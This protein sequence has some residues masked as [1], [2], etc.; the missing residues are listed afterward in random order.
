MTEVMHI[1]SLTGKRNDLAFYTEPHLNCA[2]FACGTNMNV[3]RKS[4]INALEKGYRIE[5]PE[6][7]HN[8]W[9]PPHKD[10]Q[11][12]INALRVTSR[13]NEKIHF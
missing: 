3:V 13:Q 6:G 4:A 7:D 2:G 10:D 12:A 1:Y 5:F 11:T 9:Y 8:D